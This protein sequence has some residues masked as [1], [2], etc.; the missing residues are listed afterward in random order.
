[1]RIDC[2]RAARLRTFNQRRPP[3]SK[4]RFSYCLRQEL[5]QFATRAIESERQPRRSTGSC[6]PNRRHDFRRS[7]NLVR[8]AQ[9]SSKVYSAITALDA[10]IRYQPCTLECGGCA[11]ARPSVA[12]LPSLQIA[13]KDG[14]RGVPRACGGITGRVP[15][16]FAES[17]PSDVDLVDFRL[18]VH[19][20]SERKAEGFIE[21][22][23]RT[24]VSRHFQINTSHARLLKSSQ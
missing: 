22:D 14:S 2:P 12:S 18:F 1:M 7:Q 3:F 15:A 13:S 16:E 17:R 4:S 24:V 5:P 21:T 9:D 19:R 8:P 23:S 6:L 11:N 10:P 20:T